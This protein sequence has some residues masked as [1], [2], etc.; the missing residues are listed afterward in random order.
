MTKKEI[1][2]IMDRLGMIDEGSPKDNEFAE[3]NCKDLVSVMNFV[4]D[5]FIYNDETTI[6]KFLTVLFFEA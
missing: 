2:E 1:Y 5:L 6:K 4:D 3:K